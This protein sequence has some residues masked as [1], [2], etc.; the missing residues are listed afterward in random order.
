MLLRKAY[1]KAACS[2]ETEHTKQQQEKTS[3]KCAKGQPRSQQ[4]LSTG[5][6][7][8]RL[9]TTWEQGWQWKGDTTAVTT[10]TEKLLHGLRNTVVSTWASP[11][12][13]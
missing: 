5:H 11:S 9:V 8:W 7:E 10:W 2:K 3:F 13:N 12:N 6:S 4:C 1:W